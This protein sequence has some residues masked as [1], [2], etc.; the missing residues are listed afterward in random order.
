MLCSERMKQNVWLITKS[1]FDS[2]HKKN[3]FGCNV[4]VALGKLAPVLHLFQN[5]LKGWG[6]TK[7][8]VS[9]LTWPV[10]ALGKILSPQIFL[11]VMGEVK[12]RRAGRWAGP[13]C[14]VGGLCVPANTCYTP[15]RTLNKPDC[16][17]NLSYTANLALRLD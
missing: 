4:F 9:S 14:T 11:E 12:E 5:C 13:L 8:E 6:Q 7:K 2:K 3:L 1:F 15:S 17:V 16:F 10:F